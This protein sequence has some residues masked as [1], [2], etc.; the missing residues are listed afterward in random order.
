[1]PIRGTPYVYLRCRACRARRA[2]ERYQTDPRER[3]AQIER[4]RRNRAKR[5]VVAMTVLAKP[6]QRDAGSQSGGSNQSAATC[7]G[8]SAAQPWASAM[9]TS[10]AVARMTCSAPGD[11]HNRSGKVT[12]RYAAPAGRRVR[13]RLSLTRSPGGDV[14]RAPNPDSAK[15][16]AIQHL[17]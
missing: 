11:R 14:Q 8:P 15:R 6:G 3:Q 1:M 4:V 7:R 13:H 16:N 5:G 12:W 2:R 10:H 9:D 17:N